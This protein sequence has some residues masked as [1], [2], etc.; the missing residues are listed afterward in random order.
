MK[1]KAEHVEAAAED[2]GHADKSSK[3]SRSK[4]S[5][6]R[7]HAKSDS[8]GSPIFVQLEPFV[9]NLR[10]EIDSR[11]AQVTVVFQVDD[12]S[13]EGEFKNLM[14]ALRN[15]VLMILSSK[16]ANELLTLKGK[17]HL[18]LEI[19]EAGYALLE[20]EPV[21]LPKSSTPTAENRSDTTRRED[22][23][24]RSD[25][26]DDRRDRRS[27]DESPRER[28]SLLSLEDYDTGPILAVHFSSFIV[29]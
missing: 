14:P 12:P 16:S 29:Q 27:R 28:E 2:A 7:K 22:S 15:A 5:S 24:R 6:K 9:A 10:D 17:Q 20:G 11:F 18:A 13:V 19:A 23:D 26:R 1:P 21:P 25:R 4:K 3:R 8:H